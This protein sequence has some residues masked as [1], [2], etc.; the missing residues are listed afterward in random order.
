MSDYV[1]G[2]IVGVSL[3]AV[4]VTLLLLKHYRKGYRNK[5]DERQQAGRGKAFQAGFFTL[6]IGDAAV[7]IGGLLTELPGGD[8]VWHMGAL[9]VGITVFAVTAIHFDAYV[10]M[11]DTP[12]RFMTSGGLLALAMLLSAGAN[13]MT[14][15]NTNHTFGYVNLMLGV[16]WLII[17]T[18]MVL[19]NRKK[20]GDDE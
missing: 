8:Y 10:S 17:L 13:L 18:A 4:L 6:L 2:V 11:N 20:A 7:S 3:T 1:Y 16:V 12:K 19:H 9:M 5:Y 14:E 15:E